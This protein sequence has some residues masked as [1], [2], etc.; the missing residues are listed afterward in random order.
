MPYLSAPKKRSIGSVGTIDRLYGSFVLMK[1]IFSTSSVHP[2]DR[3]DFWHSIACAQIVGHDSTPAQRNLFSADID[4]GALGEIGVVRFENSPMRVCRT[5][6]QVAKASSDELFVCRQDSGSLSIDQNGNAVILRAG[7]LSLLDPLMPYAADFSKHSQ[8]LVF[9][10]PRRWLEARLGP[11]RP[12]ISKSFGL[13]TQFQKWVSS[14]LA[15]IPGVVEKLG[16]P[17]ETVLQAQI[18]DYIALSLAEAGAASRPRISSARSIALL[19]V[20]AAIEARLADPSLNSSIVANAAGISVRYANALL[21]SDGES[22]M[23]LILARRL[24]RCLAA[25]EDR[26]H[27]HLTISDIALGWGFSDMT[28]FG[29]S[30]KVKFKILPSE[31]R[32]LSKMR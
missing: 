21:A 20:R 18:M 8:T 12:M 4:V 22:I 23:S 17:A 10:I 31:C 29:R 28:H 13:A 15:T 6:A 32:K 19:T 14:F 25:L 24:D 16:Q 26:K 11:S 7:E 2:R 27:D 3:F 30:F 1:R 9:K 5:A